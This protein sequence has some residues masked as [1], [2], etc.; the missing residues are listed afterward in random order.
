MKSLTKKKHD[1]KN[2]KS[3][4]LHFKVQG[5]IKC[6][7]HTK[8]EKFD[9]IWVT[10]K[11]LLIKGVSNN[12]NCFKQAV[13]QCEYILKYVIWVSVYITT[14]TH[15]LGLLLFIQLFVDKCDKKIHYGQR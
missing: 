7:I 12:W 2:D 15:V 4:N 13:N 10:E 3:W 9:D 1:D 6:T 11:R 8:L 5:P 14:K